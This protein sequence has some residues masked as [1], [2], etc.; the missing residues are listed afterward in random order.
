LSVYNVGIFSEDKLKEIR[1]FAKS[2]VD[3]FIKDY[4]KANKMEETK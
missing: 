4:L 1:E 2:L 3:K